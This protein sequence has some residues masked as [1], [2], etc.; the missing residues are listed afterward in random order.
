M[1]RSKF[2]EMRS[3]LSKE[4]WRLLRAPMNDACYLAATNGLRVLAR[5]E[6]ALQCA[7]AALCQRVE[8]A[9]TVDVPS[10]RYVF[11]APVLEPYMKVQLWGPDQHLGVAQDA[12]GSRRGHTYRIEHNNGTFLLRTAAPLASLLGCAEELRESTSGSVALRMRLSRYVRIDHDGPEA[13]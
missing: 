3:Q 8:G 5:T 12:I 11:G 7:V 13:A 4:L 6:D 10:V 9:L 1:V 2:P